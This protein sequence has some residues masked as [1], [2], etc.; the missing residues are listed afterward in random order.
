MVSYLLALCCML[1]CSYVLKQQV[2][3]HLLFCQGCSRSI[4]LVGYGFKPWMR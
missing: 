2:T 3:F 1:P 4:G